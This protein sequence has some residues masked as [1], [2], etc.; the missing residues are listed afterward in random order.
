VR[1]IRVT[2]S[3]GNEHD[4]RLSPEMLGPFEPDDP[5]EARARHLRHLVQSR[6]PAWAMFALVFGSMATGVLAV[7]A[8]GFF[9]IPGNLGTAVGI[10]ALLVLAVVPRAC[11]E[12]LGDAREVLEDDAPPPA[13]VCLVCERPISG[14]M[15]EPD[16]CIVCSGC[17]AAW[18]PGRGPCED[19]SLDGGIDASE[20]EGD[21]GAEG[22]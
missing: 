18:M 8:V 10:F 12:G 6:F 1:T 22:S 7:A 20:S 13:D 11:R 9:L 5:R 14:I 2:D 21:D 16:G 19:E 17:G 15:P 4:V 3:R